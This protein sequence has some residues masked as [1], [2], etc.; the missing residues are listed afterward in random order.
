[1]ASNINQVMITGNLT[2]DPE[3]RETSSGT[4]VC[5]LRVACNGS[6]K[7]DGQWESKPNYFQVNTWAGMAENCHKYLEKGSKIGVSG[8]LEWQMWE[9]KEGGTNS[10]VVIVAHQVE[11]LS[12]PKKSDKAA[13]VASAESDEGEEIPF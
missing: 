8:R 10:R 11:F 2:K 4:P 5:E 6:V 12:A 9:A 1:M 7:K 3:L 13:E